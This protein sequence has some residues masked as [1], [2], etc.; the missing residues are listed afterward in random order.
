MDGKIRK[1]EKIFE[2]VTGCHRL[3]SSS[4]NKERMKILEKSERKDKRS[5]GFQDQIHLQK[6]WM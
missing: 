6:S 4:R 5:V 3:Y 1:M 2:L